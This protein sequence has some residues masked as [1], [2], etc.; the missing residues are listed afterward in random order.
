[1]QTSINSTKDHLRAMMDSVKDA[2]FPDYSDVKPKVAASRIAAELMAVTDPDIAE[3]FLAQLPEIKRLLATDVEAIAANDPAASGREEIVYCYPAVTAM[4]YYRTAH[5][6][7][8][9]GVKVLP[10]MLTEYAH[11][12]TGIDI[13]PAAT[14]GESFAIDHGTGIVIGETAIIGKR[15]TLYQG[16]TLGAKNFRYDEQGRPVNQ[17]RHP[18]LGDDVTV[19]SNTS[20]LGR[21]TIGSGAIIGGN[22]WLTHSVPENARVLQSRSRESFSDGAG[23]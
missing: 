22:I 6:L 11:S 5:V 12:V 15:V 14:I 7:Y 19:Y 1:M 21:V 18:I 9:L 16:V 17:P 8:G 23:I 20:I 4:L 10:R 13:H 2:V 3:A